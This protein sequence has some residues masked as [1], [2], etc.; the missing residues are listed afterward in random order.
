MIELAANYN[1]PSDIT[2]D[3]LGQVYVLDAM[4]SR[5]LVFSAQAQFIREI[6]T[7]QTEHSF[8]RA[9]ALAI[10]KNVLYI[11]DSLQHRIRRFT[12]Q[13]KWLSDIKLNAP[14]PPVSKLDPKDADKPN[15]KVPVEI[16]TALPEPVAL[17][18]KDDELIYADRRWHRICY[19]ELPSGKQK[20]CMGERG[21]MEGQFEYPFQLSLDRD[22][23]L[24]VVD[25]LNARV[26]VFDRSGKY[27][28]QTGRLSMHRMYRP[29]GNVFDALD[30]QYVSDSYLGTISIYKHGRFL[31]LLLDS[32]GHEVKFLTPTRLYYHPSGYLYVVDAQ[33]HKVQKIELGYQALK[34]IPAD[35]KDISRKKCVIC[36]YTWGN[37]DDNDTLRDSQ[38]VLP[39]GALNM[40]YSCHHGA[41]L[42]SRQ[43]IPFGD[44][45]PTVYDPEKKKQDYYKKPLRE[46]EIPEVYPHSKKNDLNCTSCHTPHSDNEDQPTLYVENHNAWLRGA[47]YGSAQCEACHESNAKGDGKK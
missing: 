43:A 26:Q 5:V 40:C 17:L 44:Q 35:G 14:P 41:V 27:Y 34:H 18:I 10:D 28:S 22:G 2:T 42:D 47:D 8:N 37:E 25:V 33:A 7:A 1:Q 24:N 3:G 46:D 45:H 36:H 6:N 38:D 9:M 30:F 13:G 32:S 31:G 19:L 23:Y 21:E 39:V 16:S 29:N 15:N 12:L 4:N 20:H 11:A